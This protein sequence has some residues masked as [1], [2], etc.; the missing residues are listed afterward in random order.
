MTEVDARSLGSGNFIGRLWN[1]DVPLWKTYWIFFV[2]AALAIRFAT[3]GVTYLAFANWNRLGETGVNLAVQ[4]WYG[5]IIAYIIFISVSTWR[6]ASNYAVLQPRRSLRASLA[7]AM[8]VLGALSA[9]ANIVD[10][11]VAYNMLPATMPSAPD[12]QV[13][14]QVMMA[15]INADLPKMLD[16]ITRLDKVDFDRAGFVY[17]ESILKKLDD[18]DGTLKR[19]KLSTA[20]AS[21]SDKYYSELLKKGSKFRFIYS[22]SNRQPLGQ[23]EVTKADCS[24]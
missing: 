10:I 6:S 22:D 9:A 2:A 13:Q 17:Y 16:S 7:K 12:E 8:V 14:Y 24:P 21:C 4:S 23:F 18:V 1:G 3:L 11:V 15:G 19:L 5:L 20:K